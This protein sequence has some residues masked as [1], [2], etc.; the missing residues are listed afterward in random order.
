MVGFLS[1]LNH[2]KLHLIVDGW[3]YNIRNKAFFF[4]SA[5]DD[6]VFFF[7]VEE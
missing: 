4:C 5:S 1:D 7:V 6:G 2:S 3:C